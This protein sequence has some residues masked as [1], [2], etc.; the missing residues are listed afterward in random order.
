M[1][2]ENI[3]ILIPSFNPDKTI[4]QFLKNLRSCC[5]YPFIVINDGSKYECKNTFDNIRMIKDCFVLF[6]A[7]NLGKG[8]A[9][10]TGFNFYL[11]NF[12]GA[13][14]VTADGDGQ[15]SCNDIVKCA[16]CLKDNQKNLVLGVRDFSSSDIPWKSSL[17]NN[18][19]KIVLTICLKTKIQDSQT[20]LRGIP[21]ELIKILMNSYGE[22]FEF[23]TVMLF[24]SLNNGFEYKQYDIET[25]YE[26]NNRGTHFN[27]INDSLKIY[28]VIAKYSLTQLLMFAINSGLSAIID[29]SLFTLLFYTLLP[30]VETGRLFFSVLIARGVS[31]CFNYIVNKRIVFK[32][33]EENN[34][35]SISFCCYFLLSIVIFYL[36]YALTK[37]FNYI[38][39]DVVITF[40]KFFVDSAL[41]LLSYT[42]QKKI[43]FKRGAK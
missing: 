7:V 20:G 1:K 37:L 12:N 8:R 28:A 9:L 3:A 31:L 36:S 35:K 18:L 21:T 25:I 30:M 10:K 15:H 11:T 23:E 5:D 2:N 42:V 6:H 16:E 22:R 32:S 24:D 43:I 17:G 39:N 34:F 33:H 14:V 40:V 38:F 29:L 27:P 4:I 26:D 19:T 41:F 13:G